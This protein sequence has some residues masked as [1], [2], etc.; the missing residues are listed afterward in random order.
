MVSAEAR[1]AELAQTIA[2][3]AEIVRAV[4]PQGVRAQMMEAG[5]KRLNAGLARSLA[6]WP[7]GR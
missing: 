7:A 3:Y 4:G 1:A 6:G 5:L 2:R